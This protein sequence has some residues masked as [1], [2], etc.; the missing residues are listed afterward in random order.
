MEV[1][2]KD[3]RFPYG[4]IANIFFLG[5]FHEGNANFAE[6]KLAK[7]VNII[8]STPNSRWVGMGDY[9]DC[10]INA[11]DP[12]FNPAEIA[13]KYEIRDLKDLPRKQAD[14]VFDILSPISAE[15]LALLIGNHEQAYIKRHSF[16]IYDYISN[17][18]PNDNLKLGYDGYLKLGLIYQS[19]RDRP[20]RVV[21]IGLNHGD[22]GGGKREGYPVNKIHDLFRWWE[23]DVFI[24]GHLHKLVADQQQF[25]DT[26]ISGKHKIIRKWYGMSGCFLETFKEGNNNYFEHKGK[27]H[28]DIGMLKLEIDMTGKKDMLLK[29]IFL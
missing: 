8:K 29:R 1:I 23:G 28:S 10:I 5:D 18:F 7:A 9:I 15:C 24:A 25:N 16:D 13:H 4:E 27:P 21:K 11:K 3:I 12:R 14:Y 20:N 19:E 22:G 6:K 17:L 2:S 26:T